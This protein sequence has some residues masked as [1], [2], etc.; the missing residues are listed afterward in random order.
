[1]NVDVSTYP[2]FFDDVS[3][4][5]DPTN[6]W[7]SLHFIFDG[8]DISIP[9]SVYFLRLERDGVS[10]YYLGIQKITEQVSFIYSFHLVCSFR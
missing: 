4:T 8:A 9:P 2:S 10:Y 1:M 6:D 7:P 5:V 3:I